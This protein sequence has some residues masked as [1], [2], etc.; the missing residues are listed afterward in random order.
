MKRAAAFI[1]G[2]ALLLAAAPCVQGAAAAQ[3]QAAYEGYIVK[4]SEQAPMAL[5]AMDAASRPLGAGFY[6]VDLSLI[7]I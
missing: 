5:A 4:V 3:P 7:H 2:L 1:V 6:L